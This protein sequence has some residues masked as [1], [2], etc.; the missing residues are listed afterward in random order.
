MSK[1]EN[2]WRDIQLGDVIAERRLFLDGEEAVRVRIG[3]PLL[4]YTPHEQSACPWIIEG[5]GSGKLRYTVGI[6]RVQALWLALQMIG[7]TLYASDEYRAGRLKAFEAGNDHDDLG[8][9]VIP[10]TEDLLLKTN[11]DGSGGSGMAR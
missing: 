8:F 6:D 1:R 7:S 9:P 4:A 11:A 2:P 5:L 3:Q 10:N